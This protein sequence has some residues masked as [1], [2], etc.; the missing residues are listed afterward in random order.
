M[1]CKVCHIS[2]VHKRH[3]I[4]IFHKECVSLANDGY[5]VTYL[6]TGRH[7]NIEKGVHLLG[8]FEAI[9]SNRLQRIL[10]YDKKMIKKAMAINADIYHIHDL[11]LFRYAKY[12]KRNKAKV[13]YDSHENT[14]MQMYEKEWVPTFLRPILAR[15][16]DCIERRN[17]SY[18]DLVIAVAR[19]TYD[20][21]SKYINNVVLVENLPI[22][23]EFENIHIDYSIK[24]T[25][26]QFCYTGAIWKERGLYNTCFSIE[27][28]KD[29]QLKIAGRVDI[30]KFDEFLKSLP[31]NV[32]YVGYLTREDTLKIYEQS[33]CGLCLFEDYPNNKIDPPTKIFEYMA[34][35]IPVICSNFKSMEGVVLKYKCGISVDP[36]DRQAITDAMIY[37]V[38]NP[39]EAIEMGQNGKKAIEDKLNWEIHQQVLLKAYRRLK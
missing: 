37:L 39:T 21:F 15:V 13:V 34:A 35:G 32:S 1:S 17:I 11:E 20:R 9:G 36:H 10:F 27:P 19:S 28:L 31:K 33:Y 5:D 12:L 6:S 18:C 3:D 26:K 8:F 14:P 30:E 22:K 24:I 2:I 25:N 4:R 7:D 38:N 29:S 16:V 23:E